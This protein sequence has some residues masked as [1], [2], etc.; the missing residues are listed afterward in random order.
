[1][2]AGAEAHQ[3]FERLVAAILRKSEVG[4]EDSD[5]ATRPLTPTALLKIRNA[6]QQEVA[7]PW[8]RQ[9]ALAARGGVFADELER[10][11]EQRE[12][13]ADLIRQIV[14]PPGSNRDRRVQL[15]LDDPRLP[16]VTDYVD[17]LVSRERF[18]A[19]EGSD[20]W[21]L[22]STAVREGMAAAQYEID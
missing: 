22:I 2:Q 3:E 20:A 12:L 18:D 6:V 8:A 7:R 4:R 16:N 1:M 11:V 10:M 14:M 17:Q 19:P 5:N 13:D 15:F 21:V 9:A